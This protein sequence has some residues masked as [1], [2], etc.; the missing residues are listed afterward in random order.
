MHLPI[1]ELNFL[2]RTG[3][4]IE[5]HLIAAPSYVLLNSRLSE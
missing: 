2:G 4:E 3:R 1:W 5:H